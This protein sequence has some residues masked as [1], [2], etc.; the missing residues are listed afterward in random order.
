MNVCHLVLIINMTSVLP[1]LIDRLGDSKD[2]VREQDQ[3]L[4]LKIMDQAANPQ[5]KPPPHSPSLSLL[6]GQTLTGEAA[7]LCFQFVWERMTGGFKHKNSR[8]REGLCLCL[9]STLNV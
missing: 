9:V 3:A 7:L 1:S 6:G 8:S 4:L 2:Q 5:V